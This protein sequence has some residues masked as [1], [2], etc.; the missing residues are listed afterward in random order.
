MQ[1]LQVKN[2][3]NSEMA[4][5]SKACENWSDNGGLNSGVYFPQQA[6]Y[7]FYTNR[8]EFKQTGYV[9]FNDKKAILR[10]TKKEA[11]QAFNKHE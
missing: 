3:N 10:K 2:Y 11:I 6:F 5:Y 9:A 1:V 7:G 4:R 8:G